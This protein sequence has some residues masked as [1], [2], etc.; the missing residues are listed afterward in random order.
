MPNLCGMARPARHRIEL[1]D[2]ERSE[3]ERIA[4]RRSGPGGRC[5]GRGSCSTPPRAEA[6][7]R[8]PRGSIPRPESWAVGED[9][10]SRRAWRG[11]RTDRA[12]V[13][14]AVF[15]PEQVAEAKAIACELPATCGVP[16]SRFSRA[17]L[18]R[19]VERGVTEASASTLWRWL[20]EDAIRPWQVRSW[21]FRRDPDFGAKAGMVL[22]LY[23]R[24]SRASCSAP[25]SS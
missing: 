8:S 19:L 5:S 3:L 21:I 2:E 13:A 10:S 14:R 23:A 16:L 6:T 1:S 25:A 20:S 18:H 12:R 4:A 22:D 24:A 7:S 17:E 9:A 11:S 15:P